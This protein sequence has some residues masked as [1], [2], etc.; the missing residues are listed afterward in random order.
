MEEEARH[1]QPLLLPQRQHL[2]PLLDRAPPALPVNQV[3][4]GTPG[5]TH[6]ASSHTLG[7]QGGP[8]GAGGRARRRPARR[9]RPP[10]TLHSRPA[11]PAAVPE[12][13][14]RLAPARHPAHSLEA[15]HLHDLRQ[16]SVQLIAPSARSVAWRHHLS[17]RQRVQH[18][19]PAEAGAGGSCLAAAWRWLVRGSG[20]GPGMRLPSSRCWWPAAVAPPTCMHPSLPCTLSHPA[21]PATPPR[22]T[23]PGPAACRV[24]CTASGA[25]STRRDA[26]PPPSRRPGRWRGR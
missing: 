16:L 24:W 25:R 1:A 13:G 6:G 12:A 18:L 8:A 19:H 3:P 10:A 22:S 2:A 7:V 20:A 4:A 9:L 11:W 15:H 21:Q 26:G 23:P 5:G 17:Q 14:P